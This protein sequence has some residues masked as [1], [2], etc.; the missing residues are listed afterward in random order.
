MNTWY[1]KEANDINE[2]LSDKQSK[3]PKLIRKL[4]AKFKK[5]KIVDNKNI[6]IVSKKIKVKKITEKIN[7][8]LEKNSVKNIAISDYLCSIPEFK[9]RIYTKKLHILDGRKLFKVMTIDVIKYIVEKQGTELESQ[10][11]SILTNS[12]DEGTVQNIVN[13]ASKVK[14]LNIITDNIEDFK[15]LETY[16]YE[17]IGM[18]IKISSNPKKAL[19]KSNIIVN[20]DF[21]KEV[22]NK[23]NIPKHSIIINI[24][25]KIDI[26]KKQ[27]VG[28][29]VQ[30]FEPNIPESF[31]KNL[32]KNNLINPFNN[33]VLC[34]SLINLNDSFLNIRNKLEEETIIIKQLIG[35]KGILSDNEW[36]NTSSKNLSKST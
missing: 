3:F 2:L 18:M 16:I 8:E 33:T 1:I 6:I 20:F 21:N 17:N 24:K 36:K 22:L 25:D 35:N 10:E 23:Y 34:E 11:I 12:K 32:N 30:Y 26:I 4:I 19:L 29:N 28:V 5:V 7:K 27:F 31:A 9:E 13:I 15:F 14:M